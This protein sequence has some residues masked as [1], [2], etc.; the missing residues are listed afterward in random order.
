[1][2]IKKMRV[3]HLCSPI[4]YD[5][6][7]L[8]LSWIAESS[9][10]RQKESRVQ[11]AEDDKF[12]ALVSDSGW[13]RLDSLDYR[14][15][16]LDGGCIRLKPFTRYYWNVSVRADNGEEGSS[17]T[18]YF[19]TAKCREPWQAD[20]ITAPFLESP[21]FRGT[22]RAQTG[23]A[24]RIC[25]CAVGLYEVYCNG[26]KVTQEVLLPGYHSYDLHLMYQTF[27]LDE[28]L[29]EGENEIIVMLGEGWYMGRF[30]FGGGISNTYGSRM[31]MI[32]EIYV[33]GKLET[34]SDGTWQCR[35]SPVI[36]SNIYDGEVWDARL[37]E[38]GGWDQ[39]EFL[40]EKAAK[41][42]TGRLTERLSPPVTVVEIIRPVEIIQTPGGDT[43]LDFGQNLAGWFTF[44]CEAPKGSKICVDCAELMQDG[45]FYRENL[46]TAKAA[47]TYISNGRKKRV[48]PHFTFFG[49][50]YLRVKGIPNPETARF[51]AWVLSSVSEQTGIWETGLDSVNRLM[52]NTRWGQLG[53]FIEVPTDC[54]QRDERMGWTGDAQIF[55]A[56]ACYQ[57]DSAAFYA[58]YMK[59]V[60]LEQQQIEGSV[61]F[62]VP[63]PKVD[64]M[65]GARQSSGSCAWSDAA[66]II[67]W[68]V[69][70]MYGDKTLLRSEYAGMK[71]WVDYIR[72]QETKDH[73]WTSGFHFA[74]WL[75]L[76]HDEPGPMGK[77]DPYYCASGYY[78]YSA[79]LTAKAANVLGYE[80]D[81]EFYRELAEKIRTSVRKTYFLPNGL[82]V[83]DT[84]TACVLAL[85]FDLC[86]EEDR[87]KIADRLHQKLVENQM[88]L[89]TGFVGTGYLCQV[90]SKAGLNADAV[91]LLLQEE[92]PG[93]LYQVKMGATTIW[94]RWDSILPDGHINPE[95]MNS[96]NHYA[97]G[98]VSQ[99]IYE[100]VFGISPLEPGFRK[101]LFCPKPD[102]RLRYS[103]GIYKSAAG[104][105]RFGWEKQG[106]EF[107]CYLEVPF[108]CTAVIQKVGEPP[109]EV[110]A[111]M[112][113]FQ[114]R[115]MRGNDGK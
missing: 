69:Y 24:V 43:V 87:G 28:L 3:N 50:R 20:W 25:M 40:E 54:P 47:L 19:E 82:C 99:W 72:T 13:R 58:K 83:S 62:I 81:A 18:A 12:L 90:L 94:E 85:A 80:K 93:W 53:N 76:D 34:C 59:D 22:F 96:L 30:G 88:H 105:Y 6:T 71:A 95:S 114:I 91:S 75:A 32:C 56:T 98:A 37:K 2:K 70:Q 73:L 57:Y 97:N 16:A 41:E 8:S 33:D 4:G 49:F 5:Y 7:N 60:W 31:A 92:M 11:V 78:Y 29:K 45:E 21:V 86:R 55:C 38:N 64:L 89:D 1:M 68:T 112:H 84:Q 52:E 46:R 39:I 102:E 103:K 48:R 66:V 14:P 65:P 108:D 36:E 79:M 61:P 42:M 67:P 27:A 26:K 107:V 10:K 35:R 110:E 15:S 74:D 109:K 77:T 23:Q 106:E 111:G 115:G 113:W 44:T 9:G 17:D 100:N 104:T 101:V 51:E 63:S